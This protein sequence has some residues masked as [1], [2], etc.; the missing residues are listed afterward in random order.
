MFKLHLISQLQFQG[1]NIHTVVQPQ[2]KTKKYNAKWC[3]NKT[4]SGRPLD[5][6]PPYN[7]TR[8]MACASTSHGNLSTTLQ[9]TVQSLLCTLE[10]WVLSLIARTGDIAILWQNSA[11]LT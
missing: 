8:D 4:P 9:Q 5:Q 11:D 2:H 7:L 3:L 6:A 1:Q 10:Y